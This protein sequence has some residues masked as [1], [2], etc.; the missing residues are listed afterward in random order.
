VLFSNGRAE[1]YSGSTKTAPTLTGI[2]SIHSDR[3]KQ[4]LAISANGKNYHH[5]CGK[6]VW[7]N[8]VIA[9][10]LTELEKLWWRRSRGVELTRSGDIKV[11]QNA[12]AYARKLRFVSAAL[13]SGTVDQ[14]IALVCSGTDPLNPDSDGD[15]LYDGWEI[16]IG[17]NPNAPSTLSADSDGDGMY[18]WFE[19]LYGL[20][21]GVND[22][23]A[24]P[25]NDGLTN[26][27][28]FKLGINDPAKAANPH[29]PDTDGDGLKDGEEVYGNHPEN[30]HGYIT[31][32]YD[33]DSDDDGRTDGEEIL[34]QYGIHTDPNN[35]DSDGD[36]LSDGF[37]VN[38]VPP[39]DPNNPDSDGD[40]LSDGFEVNR[41]P[42]LDPNN[43]DSDGDTMPDRWEIEHGLDPALFADGADDRDG[44]GLNNADEFAA[45]TDPGK[46]HSDADTL[47]DGQ[48]VLGVVVEHGG[49]T[50]IFHSDPLKPH[51]DGD[52]LSDSAEVF[53]TVVV[54]DG[55]AYTFHSDPLDQDS[56]GDGLSDREEVFGIEVTHAGTT[57]TFH[58]DP[59]KSDSD[60]DGLSDSNE[61]LGIDVICAGKGAK[62]H[63]DPLKLDSDG[64]G[65][66]DGEEVRGDLS[67]NAH[68]YITDPLR[69]DTDGDTLSDKAEILGE[70]IAG[71]RSNPLL[72]D[73]DGDGMD[74]GVEINRIPATDPGNPDTDGDGMRDDWEIKYGFDPLSGVNDALVGW[75]QFRE[76]SGT[77]SADLSGN[78]N[79]AYI[80]HTNYVGW[81]K[82]A[83][84]GKSL[85]F[86]SYGSTPN[87]N[88][89]YVT[90]PGLA[91]TPLSQ[92]FTFA[93]WV[94]AESYGDYSCVMTKA[95]DHDSWSDGASIYYERSLEF[96]AGSWSSANT[97]KSGVVAT[98]RWLHLCGTY[99]GTNASFYIDGALMGVAGNVMF[100]SETHAPLQIGT[101]F[102]GGVYAWQGYIADV[103]VYSRALSAD[104]VSDLL[105]FNGDCDND[106]LSNRRE[107]ENNCNPQSADTDEDGMSDSDELSRVPPCD[108]LNNDSDG[109][110]MPDGWEVQHGLNPMDAGD[111][112]GDMD[113]D[114]LTNLEEYKL[115]LDPNNRDTDGDWMGDGWEVKYGLNPL[116]A[117]DAGGHGDS[118]G[119]TNLEEYNLG[120]DPSNSDTDYD[121]MDDGWEVKYGFDPLSGVNDSLVGWWQFREGAGTNS[122]DL[123][124]NGNHAYI[125]HRSPH[126]QWQ[127][128]HDTPLGNA[129]CFQGRP[130]FK[131][132]DDGGGGFVCVPGLTRAPLSTGFTLSV[133]VK[134]GYPTQ[135]AAFLTISSDLSDL[136]DGTSL[137]R[138]NGMN[139]YAHDDGYDVSSKSDVLNF[140]NH[141]CGVYNPKTSS[142]SIYVNGVLRSTRQNMPVVSDVA[143]PLWIGTVFENLSASSS[144]VTC[145]PFDGELADARFY[146]CALSAAEVKELS[147]FNNDDDGD[148]LTNQR[149]CRHGADPYC[150]DTDGDGLSDGDE[151]LG[152]YVNGHRYTSNPASRDT[153]G[154]GIEDSDEL[155][156]SNGFVT[157]PDNS[158][159][160]GDGLLDGWEIKYGFNPVVRNY[161]GEDL[162]GDGLDLL[163]ECA[164]NTDPYKA[165]T[166][167]DGVSD[168]DEVLIKK[169]LPLN[170]DTDDDM[171]ADG[172][173]EDPLTADD[174]ESNTD[175][176]NLV[177]WQELFYRR[178]PN[179]YDPLN[180]NN[181]T[182]LYIT[183]FSPPQAGNGVLLVNSHPFVIRN[184]PEITLALPLDTTHTILLTNAPGATVSVLCAGVMVLDKRTGGFAN[185]GQGDGSARL[186]L[187][188][189]RLPGTVS[190]TNCLHH[191]ENSIKAEITSG[192]PGNYEWTQSGNVIAYGASAS[193][194][195]KASLAV[196]ELTV[197]F[198]PDNAEG[199][200]SGDPF[201]TQPMTMGA[202]GTT[203]PRLQVTVRVNKC[204]GHFCEHGLI[205]YM[206]PACMN[207]TRLAI[208][209]ACGEAALNCP[210][211]FVA[212]GLVDLRGIVDPQQRPIKFSRP[213]KLGFENIWGGFS[214][215]CDCECAEYGHGLWSM[216]NMWHGGTTTVENVSYRLDVSNPATKQTIHAPVEVT[217]DMPYLYDLIGKYAS[218]KFRDSLIGLKIPLNFD[219]CSPEKPVYT[220]LLNYYTVAS[221][222]FDPALYEQS[223][224]GYR[225]LRIR[226][227]E[228]CLDSIKVYT[229]SILT[230]GFVRLRGDAGGRLRFSQTRNASISDA[231]NVQTNTPGAVDALRTF[232]LGSTFG[233]VYTLK[234]ELVDNTNPRVGE[235]VIGSEHIEI[236]VIRAKLKESQYVMAHEATSIQ[237]G[238]DYEY[239]RDPLG[240]TLLIDG[241]S[242]SS[243]YKGT[244]F[245]LSSLAI[246]THTVTLRSNTFTDLK[247][248]AALY[249]VK[250]EI[251]MDGNRDGEIDFDEP[252]D[253]KYLFW[254]NDDYDW[255]HLNEGMTQQDDADPLLH[256][257]FN[258]NCIGNTGVGAGSCERDLEDFTRLNI[259]VDENIV[260]IPGV[261]Y[262]LKFDNITTPTPSINIFKAIVESTDYLKMSAK[263]ALQIQ[264]RRINFQPIGSNEVQ[265]DGQFIKTNGGTATFL[266]EGCSTGQGDLAFL[267]KID[268]VEICS[269]VVNLK[270]KDMTYFYDTY[271]IGSSGEKWEVQVENSAT[272]RT[273]GYKPKTNEKFL[274]VHGWNMDAVSKKAWIET[275]FKRLWWQG[276]RG[277][278]ALFDWPTLDNFEWYNAVYE[279]RHFDNSEYRSW[280]SSDALAAV[281]WILNTDGQLRVLAH[282]MGNVA[283]ASAIRK[284]PAKNLHTYIAT[285]AAISAQYYDNTADVRQPAGRFNGADT[286]DIVGHY[287]QLTTSTTPPYMSGMQ[288]RVDN[289]Y[290]YYNFKD[291]ALA[292]WELNNNFKPDEYAP[293]YFDYHGS[294]VQYDE[295][296]GDDCFYKYH[297]QDKRRE[298]YSIMNEN[299]RFKIFSYIAESRSG[300]LGQI[301]HI[302][303]VSGFISFDLNDKLGY[304]AQHYSHSRQFR[305]HIADEWK[306]WEQVVLNCKFKLN[307][308]E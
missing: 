240:F 7:S 274:L 196:G 272:P 237:F 176:D 101:V 3:D 102:M 199:S 92:G 94:L 249:V 75:W 158:D 187:P 88:G 109:D 120:T 204:N 68:G 128:E 28:E 77:S 1:V 55:I 59:L 67:G 30:T 133:W 43:P 130:A 177:L 47:T 170:P 183:L 275:A 127:P 45:G 294:I 125:T 50:Y 41:V 218:A 251:A 156:L 53:G 142:I 26:Y 95:S 205:K 253:K 220:N 52:G 211:S 163:E 304:D 84:V 38:R 20:N 62:F 214:S 268:G 90:V 148:G 226:G 135:Y 190:G 159:T 256:Q 46:K 17:Y 224:S 126:V 61:V 2:E 81:S 140:W 174:A 195:H 262:W 235:R 173:D 238:I 299:E 281:F 108:P 300:A 279:L 232:Y 306:Y 203:P 76:E 216:G 112:N 71:Y 269:A 260:N 48:E 58:S 106:G 289:L 296:N 13:T 197:N 261:T 23:A 282:S 212:G 63:S 147:A 98:Q 117:G 22:A 178:D 230:E 236:E 155:S 280:L 175:G 234:Y 40:G 246:G 301:N 96:Y 219:N 144:S 241:I 143:A 57:Y 138:N 290:N 93:A 15:G 4:F 233:G 166:D 305:S 145:I 245:D 33:A 192:L 206:C 51:S 16:K 73:S 298:K 293:Y 217:P 264:E 79:T 91:G 242:K 307:K 227:G 201:I 172:I 222:Y 286:P 97:I 210:C 32:P 271:F 287:A 182:N 78:G 137:Y 132:I 104:A 131:D 258:D 74:D 151:V 146:T 223:Y 164:N 168:G 18:D 24:D 231:V 110:T 14:G 308:G 184:Q 189:I 42:P 283:V 34:S 122:V 60:G 85:H 115:N 208:C 107:Y 29:N 8:F 100:A 161:T 141:V 25:D 179:L 44:D 136:S 116:D 209:P 5:Y 188:A 303:G 302:G 162:D 49:V 254:V 72:A 19:L 255:A 10:N 65:I 185:G 160:D 263:S 292:H 124:G 259:R 6:R 221:I 119:L 66:E 139:F 277:K 243:D 297:S 39:L 276:Y 250:V 35:P 21:P 270:L 198:Y 103:R 225:E 248:T 114:D 191:N 105:E 87:Y 153:D 89:G 285:Q 257:N 12:T 165:D 207:D 154:D 152:T 64:D 202:T 193:E 69:F 239:S 295:V 200:N 229:R 56:D 150:P 157:D 284:Y 169:T 82:N 118:D 186:T 134:E 37:E 228:Q 171:L 252:E 273:G 86:N 247:D 113:E 267:V 99:D 36:G 278:V 9:N 149:E 83:P 180:M 11:L 167:A 54:H 194:M 288:G 121:G 129:L 123:S 111:A 181:R 213:V 265:I 266:L 215:C 27:Q 31:L 291:W 244:A 70:N 80:L